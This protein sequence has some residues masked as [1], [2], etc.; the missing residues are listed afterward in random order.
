MEE[1]RAE[2]IRTAARDRLASQAEAAGAENRPAAGNATAKRR[3]RALASVPRLEA[4]AD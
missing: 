1:L 2:A 3:A 4:A